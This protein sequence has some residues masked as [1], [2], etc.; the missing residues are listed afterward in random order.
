MMTHARLTVPALLALAGSLVGFAPPGL[1]DV[2]REP[3]AT[4]QVDPRKPVDRVEVKRLTLSP[5]AK[6]APHTHPGP[7]ISYLLQGTLIVRI[8]G[9]PDKT[10]KPGDVIYEPGNTVIEKFDNASPAE[11][12]VFITNYL[13]SADDKDF[14]HF[15]ADD[16]P[17]R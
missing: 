11:P 7:T 17:G 2:T 3:L 6:T 8:A 9:G 10:F 13:L 14:I 16:K 5:G 12:A 15:L 1:G 4:L